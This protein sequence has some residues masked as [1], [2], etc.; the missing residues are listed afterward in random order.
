MNKQKKKSNFGGAFSDVLM[1]EPLSTV[2]WLL[3]GLVEVDRL[4]IIIEIR[5]SGTQGS[6]QGRRVYKDCS[7]TPTGRNIK[8]LSYDGGHL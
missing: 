3:R 5:W 6:R 4:D 1:P 2:S 7:Q 8:R